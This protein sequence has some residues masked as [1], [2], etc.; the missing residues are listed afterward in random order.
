MNLTPPIMWL[1]LGIVLI[2]LDF[3]VPDPLTLGLVAGFLALLVAALATVVPNTTV[4]ILV[5]VVLS[6]LGIFLAQRLQPKVSKLVLESDEALTLTEI[7]S[8]RSGRVMYEGA[9]WR[10]VCCNPDE[11]I[12]PKQRV[13]VV[14]RE[15][16]TL[17]VLPLE[18]ASL[19]EG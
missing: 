10:A 14:G 19:G 4:Q 12:A 13:Q 17:I 3:V 18:S 7:P 9:S 2:V 15:G 6:G 8:H 5:W 1:I 11:A 16:N